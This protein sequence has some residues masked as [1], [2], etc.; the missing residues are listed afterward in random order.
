MKTA[1]L[2]AVIGLALG[3]QNASAQTYGF[4]CVTD[5]AASS[6]ADGMAS[7]RMQ[8][9]PGVDPHSVDFTFT[10]FSS[11]SPSSSITEVYFADGS[12]LSLA[13]VNGSAGVTFSQ[14][15]GASPPDLPGGKNLT[16]AFV[17]TAGFAADIGSGS[18]AKG[19]ENLKPGGVQE[20]LTVHFILQPGKSFADTIATLDGPLGDGN[21]LRVGVHVRGFAMPFGATMSESF[22]NAS[23]VPEPSGTMALGLV[24][25]AGLMLRR[26]L[27]SSS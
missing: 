16:P 20:F 14:V 18:N 9:S 12:L 25:A 27:I 10:N 17:T 7:L 19:V 23:A 3:A 4:S 22:V 8:V 6:C 13:S 24:A 26:R 15:G 1:S 2:L 11:S 21:D 5:N